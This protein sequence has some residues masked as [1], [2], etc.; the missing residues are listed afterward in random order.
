MRGSCIPVSLLLLSVYGARGA[1]ETSSFS[2]NKCNVVLLSTFLF[3]SIKYI[4]TEPRALT[5]LPKVTITVNACVL[6]LTACVMLW[7]EKN[8]LH[9]PERIV[10]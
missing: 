4:C 6:D 1:I 5:H 9:Q 7:R 10:R 2:D 8:R 3:G